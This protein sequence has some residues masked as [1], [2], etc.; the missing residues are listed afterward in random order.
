MALRCMSN[1][2]YTRNSLTTSLLVAS[3]LVECLPSTVA[4]DGANPIAT[5]QEALASKTPS[6]TPTQ[7]AKKDTAD[8]A[9]AAAKLEAREKEAEQELR[10]AQRKLEETQAE[11]APDKKQT[12]AADR[13]VQ[14][15]KQIKLL[16]NQQK[17]VQDS[18]DAK[19]KENEKLEERLQQLREKGP[20]ETPPYSVLLLDQKRD[21]L[22]VAKAKD[23]AQAVRVASD[24]VVRAKE[25]L[26]QAITQRRLSNE[27]YKT[28]K[29]DAKASASAVLAQ[30]THKEEVA[31]DTLDLRRKELEERTIEQETN[32]LN[33]E[34]LQEY[35]TALNASAR[36]SENDYLERLADI[37]IRE[38]DLQDQ[39]NNTTDSL[40]RA[41]REYE[42]TLSQLVDA[43][44][45][46]RQLAEAARDAW[47]TGKDVL[48]EQKRILQ[49]QLARLS[50]R[51]TAWKRRYEV[52]AG[53]ANEQEMSEW[54]KATK[55]TIQDLTV[56]ER[57]QAS[58]FGDLRKSLVTVEAKLEAA[59]EAPE[60]VRR[61]IERQE[62]FYNDLR[63]VYDGNMNSIQSNIRL[64]ERLAEELEGRLGGPTVWSRI[65]E[66]WGHVST[67]WN[68]PIT[69]YDERPIT[70]GKIIYGV[71]LFVLGIWLSRRLSDFFARRLFSKVGLHNGAASAIQ[72]VSFYILVVAFGLLALKIAEVPLT[73]FTL[74]GGAL[75]IGIGFGSQNIVNNF[76]S[77]LIL[78]AERPVRVGDLVQMESL[79]GVVEKIGAR[80]TRIRTGENLEIIV[81][82]SKF[83][84]NDVVNWTLSD[85][86]IRAG[87]RVGV[88]YGSPTREVVKLLKRAVDE[89]GLVLKQPEPFC[90]FSDF[91]DNSLIFDLHFWILVRTLAERRVIESDIRHRI[92]SLFREAGVTIA[93]PQ[94]DIHLGQIKPLDVRLLAVESP[95]PEA[96][97][98]AA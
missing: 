93:F 35:V 3:L 26:D 47:S 74:L 87:V 57:I 88:A 91:G 77:G 28:A 15:K 73:V 1:S 38:D 62:Q 7:A 55:T 16:L 30:A 63:R 95:L 37:Q 36:F 56:V 84:E 32:K 86:K 27:R 59:K 34:Y 29:D 49:A 33:V 96:K 89:H 72:S 65:A 75:A 51:R 98:E 4:A 71:V 9:A 18:I 40:N 44:N 13:D 92:D 24:A 50:L 76:I 5:L 41:Q 83:L 66:I 17:T 80:S 31:K 53:R 78:L 6:E 21:E 70:V 10:V 12:E 8:T 94:R 52:S 43:Q 45:G 58:A 14:E 39:I 22:A 67:V 20:S 97:A 42:R 81:P 48:N 85:D 69:S 60:G 82:N 64:H 23:F 54:L 90:W 68:Y 61:W 19:K 46:G 2:P 11:G 79:F 25:E